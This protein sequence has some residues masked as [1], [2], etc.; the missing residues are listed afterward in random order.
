MA[1]DL[2]AI[3]VRLTAVGSTGILLVGVLRKPA[4]RAVGAEAAYWLWLLVPASLLAV[5]L[6]EAPS[7]L[8]GPESYI[9]PLVIR[10]IGAPLELAPQVA[11]CHHAWGL[12]VV[13]GAG[14]AAALAYFAC[15]QQLLKRSLGVLERRPDG[16]Y[17]S[18]SAKQPM[19]VGTWQPRIVLPGDFE[20]RYTENERAV[21]LAHEL[22]H[23]GRRDALTNGIALGL[24]CLFWFN[25]IAYWA[26]GRFRFD[27]EVAC[28]AAVL[29]A[30]SVSRRL[31]ARALAKTELT[32]WMAIAFGWRRR[33]PL[34]ERVAMLG[35]RPP[36]RI[37]RFV[38]YALALMLMLS[39]TYVVW[40]AR[41]EKAPPIA[42]FRTS[43]HGT[44]QATGGL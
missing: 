37:Q 39:A 23:I 19:L 24:V 27:Q 31:Y 5:F 32:T 40:A 18:R 15:C 29:R 10:A 26:W 21:I 4:R 38:G 2:F 14:A 17:S 20:T 25:P 43:A 1:N 34:V 35:H 9:S 6:P 11:I 22:A 30:A 44:P 28:D 7:C 3:L 16:S 33:H 13:W 36:S 8:C 41:P 12:T 42:S